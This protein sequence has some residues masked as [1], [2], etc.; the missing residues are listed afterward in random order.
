[1][2]VPQRAAQTESPHIEQSKSSKWAR[3]RQQRTPASPHRTLFPTK[4]LKSSDFQWLSLPVSPRTPRRHH[5]PRIT[6]T[7]AIPVQRTRPEA[8]PRMMRQQSLL[9]RRESSRPSASLRVVMGK[10]GMRLV[11]YNLESPTWHIAQRSETLDGATLPCRA[12][13]DPVFRPPPGG[14]KRGGSRGKGSGHLPKLRLHRRDV[15]D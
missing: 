12:L 3:R 9:A 13:Y 4:A 11:A 2:H 5:R 7:E 8:S 6:R 1:M 15:V 10:G 14:A